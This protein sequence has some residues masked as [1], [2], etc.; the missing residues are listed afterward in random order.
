MPE[1]TVLKSHADHE[2]ARHLLEHN[3][4]RCQP[5]VNKYNLRIG[6]VSEFMPNDDRL[7]GLN[8]NRGQ[9]IKVR[10]RRRSVRPV[11]INKQQIAS[12]QNLKNTNNS[13]N[14]NGKNRGKR[15]ELKTTVM[16]M[17]SFDPRL[18]DRSGTEFLPDVDVL[19]TLLHELCHNLHPNHSQ[20]F[21]AQ[22][23]KFWEDIESGLGDGINSNSGSYKPSSSGSNLNDSLFGGT[24]YRLS[25]VGV[26]SSIG[27]ADCRKRAA[28]A[29]LGRNNYSQ[30]IGN[31]VYKLSSS[32]SSSNGQLNCSARE[33]AVRAALKRRQD[34]DALQCGIIDLSIDDE[35]GD[36]VGQDDSDK[37]DREYFD[38]VAV[39][40]ILDSPVPQ[41][42]IVLISDDD[43]DEDDSDYVNNIK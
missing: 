23:D 40:E 29:A 11:A 35:D 16:P 36:I 8:I 15:N 13:K 9:H 3:W 2:K 30:S 4:T 10:L 38:N 17:S 41:D 22:L 43:D 39:I 14:N 26:S 42:P 37:Y 7:L 19:G 32:S 1:L 24:G 21:Y 5:I 20:A 6:K 34:L 33:L 27:S 31:G 18:V 25:S 28:E 12:K